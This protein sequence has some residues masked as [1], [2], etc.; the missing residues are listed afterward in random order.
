MRLSE[1]IV[2]HTTLRQTMGCFFSILLAQVDCTRWRSLALL[3]LDAFMVDRQIHF[4]SLWASLRI[5]LIGIAFMVLRRT[6]ILSNALLSHM[7]HAFWTLR[8]WGFLRWNQFW[9][10]HG[11]LLGCLDSW[12][13]LLRCWSLTFVTCHSFLRGNR[14]VHIKPL[15]EALKCVHK[16]VFCLLF[17]FPTQFLNFILC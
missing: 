16:N 10:L 9:N 8:R 17:L 6:N 14:A 5:L 1:T 15:D 12:P 7:T 11:S 13:V 2:A 3:Q 4:D